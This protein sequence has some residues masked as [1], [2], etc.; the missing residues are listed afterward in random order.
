MYSSTHQNLAASPYKLTSAS[1]NLLR[2]SLGCWCDHQKCMTLCLWLAQLITGVT[3]L[4][5][6]SKKRLFL[7]VSIGRP[8]LFLKGGFSTVTAVTS[9]RN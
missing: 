3:V 2:Y 9:A 5:R 6:F 1:A 4:M 8:K 7:V